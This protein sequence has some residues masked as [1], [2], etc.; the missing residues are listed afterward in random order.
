MWVCSRLSRHRNAEGRRVRL[1]GGDGDRVSRSGPSTSPGHAARPRK[2][3]DSQ[4]WRVRAAAAEPVYGEAMGSD[5][6]IRVDYDL[7]GI[8]LATWAGRE[9]VR[10]ALDR[11]LARH[12][13]NAS[14]APHLRLRFLSDMVDA[15]VRDPDG[16]WRTVYEPVSGT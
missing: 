15:S 5:S 7:H 11:R 9:D 3:A 6:D 13:V 16:A 1:A 12:R 10:Q 2:R 4:R 14:V 8:R